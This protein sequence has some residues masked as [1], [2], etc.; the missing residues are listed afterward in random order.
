MTDLAVA[1]ETGIIESVMIGGDLSRLT[2]PQRVAYYQAVCKSL[3]LNPLTKPFDYI[4]LNGKLTLYAKKDATEQLRDI[5]G[6][7]ITA[8]DKEIISGCYAVTA[9]AVNR[10][11]KTDISTGIVF[12]ESLK[13]EALA[14]AMMKAETK[15]KRRVTL[16]ICGLGMLDETETDAIPGASRV[17]VDAETGEIVTPTVKV[18]DSIP[19]TTTTPA[20][21]PT[22]PK[23]ESTSGMTYETAIA[24][25]DSDGVAYGDIETEVHQH[26]LMTITASLKKAGIT[27]AEREEKEFKKAAII[28]ILNY[29]ISHK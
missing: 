17:A 13:G 5:H 6:I 19:V 8:L 25:K 10:D 24:V 3:G 27:D 9:H 21:K 4:T 2:P 7:S 20:P 12:I 18:S 15:S 1:L 23:P 16:S 29:R 26:K 11:G 28:T 22:A 14:N